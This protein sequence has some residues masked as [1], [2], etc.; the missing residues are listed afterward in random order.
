MVD[1]ASLGSSVVGCTGSAPFS[2]RSTCSM[3]STEGNS[4]IEARKKTLP[5]LLK[6][7]DRKHGEMAA[8]LRAP[9]LPL[10]AKTSRMQGMMARIDA[11]VFNVELYAGLTEE[12][13]EIASGAP[14]DTH[15][16]VHL[17]SAGAPWTRRLSCTTSRAGWTSATSGPSTPASPTATPPSSTSRSARCTV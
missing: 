1:D 17:S 10:K 7:I 5:E 3:K 13:V 9:V 16:K 2:L 15:A 4:L 12:I 8:W 11:R 6:E 14:A